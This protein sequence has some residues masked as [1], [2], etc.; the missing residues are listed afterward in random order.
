MTASLIYVYGV[1]RDADGAPAEALAGLRGV[2]DAPVHLVR[3]GDDDE[4]V[5]AVSPVPAQDFQE[6]ALTAHLEDLDWL[7]SV[8]RAHHRV[9]EALAARTTV[10]PLRLATV[11]LD[12]DRIRDM[13]EARREAFAERL[14]D[15]AGHEEWGVKISVE[16]PPAARHPPEPSAKPD[17]AAASAADPELSPGRAYLSRRRAQRHARD[18]AHRDAERAAE[19]VEAAARAHAVDRVRHRPQQGELA[20]GPGENVINDAYLVPLR[21]A[22]SFRTDVMRAADGLSG[23]CVEVTGPWAPY[24]FSADGRTEPSKRAAP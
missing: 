20:R 2:A 21:H 4:V 12:D 14:T 1:A 16:A 22:E 9:I 11:Y 24:S 6:A 18:E 15:L 3:A 13:L 10:L 23:V 7:E 19:R 17:P 8:A 5:A